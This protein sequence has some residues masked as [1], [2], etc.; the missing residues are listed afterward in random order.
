MNRLQIAE[1]N[2]KIDHHNH[3]MNEEITAEPGLDRKKILT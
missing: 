3:Q 2:N 1:I